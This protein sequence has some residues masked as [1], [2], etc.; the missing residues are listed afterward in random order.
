MIFK[1]YIEE[2]IDQLEEIKEEDINKKNIM[3][4]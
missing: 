3:K 4:E 1:T 2:N